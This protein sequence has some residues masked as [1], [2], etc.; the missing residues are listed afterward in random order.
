MRAKFAIG[1][2]I[3]LLIALFGLGNSI[4]CARLAM[5]AN[6]KFQRWL[7]DRP[8]ELPIDL[9]KPGE[10]TSSFHQT[11]GIS[12]GENIFL[13]VDPP[14][15]SEEKPEELLKGLSA[16]II[17]SDKHNREVAAV[18]MDSKSVYDGR[19]QEGILLAGFCPF[20]EG[21]YGATI[22]VVSGAE[23]L[24]GRGQKMYAKYLVCGME[25]F[26]AYILGLFSF[27]SGLIGFIAA[28]CS[29]PGLLRGGFW[30]PVAEGS[31][32]DAGLL[33][34]PMPSDQ[35]ESPKGPAD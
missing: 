25:L 21:D 26:P 17:V 16:V 18:K 11:C 5:Q 34:P 1:R 20:A 2:T 24:A 23:R 12:H 13:K 28:A 8:M 7:S 15:K 30:R 35:V 33:T 29:L 6:A 31:K 32:G 19:F 4:H 22:R 10:T 3:G 14:L 27:G 9:S